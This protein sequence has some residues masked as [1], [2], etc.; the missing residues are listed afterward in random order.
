MSKPELKAKPKEEAKSKVEFW[1]PTEKENTKTQYGCEIL[2]TNV[3]LK[4]ARTSQ[5]PNDAHIVSYIADGELRYDLTRGSRTSLFDMYYDKFKSGLK[6][7]E[8]GFGNVKPN[9]WG[10]RAPSKNKKRK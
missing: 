5:A 4:E 2:M 10:Y 9:L 8:Y 6:S 3:T 1:T 7:I